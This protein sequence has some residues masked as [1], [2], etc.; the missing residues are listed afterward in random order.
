MA[1]AQQTERYEAQFTSVPRGY[2]NS[3]TIG[4]L[5]KI[6]AY[7]D[8]V[9]FVGKEVFL[10]KFF[11]TI[12]A[13][14]ITL[15]IVVLC[16]D[17]RTQDYLFPLLLELNPNCETLSSRIDVLYTYGVI[18]Q[19]AKAFEAVAP[20][21]ASNVDLVLVYDSAVFV[22]HYVLSQFKGLN[23]RRP[24]IA[25][26]TTM[27]SAD[28]RCYCNSAT[29]FAYNWNTTYEYVK[30]AQQ[31]FHQPNRRPSH[32]EFFEWNYALA[33]DVA[34]WAAMKQSVPYQFSQPTQERSDKQPTTSSAPS[35]L[36]SVSLPSSITATSSIQASRSSLKPSA[37]S[38]LDWCA[39]HKF[40]EALDEAFQ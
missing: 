20:M 25:Y 19:F 9:I 33:N 14:E 29:H 35:S 30:V 4:E 32:K 37:A 28:I 13:M 6:Y 34:K 17:S 5:L 15:N 12:K 38:L 21:Q 3:F 36:N 22:P 31:V 11:K 23:H 26:I 18:V 7:S 40:H 8:E 10:E 2:L 16:K 1:S 24:Q 27:D 39:F